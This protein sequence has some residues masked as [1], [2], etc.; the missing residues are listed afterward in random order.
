MLAVI[1]RFILMPDVR[2]T[3]IFPQTPV[4]FVSGDKAGMHYINTRAV[5]ALYQDIILKTTQATSRLVTELMKHFRGLL[6]ATVMKTIDL[7]SRDA[8]FLAVLTEKGEALRARYEQQ[9]RE[10]KQY[11]TADGQVDYP[12]PLPPSSGI[13]TLEQFFKIMAN[14]GRISS[15]FTRS[16]FDAVELFRLG[17]SGFSLYSN[18]NSAQTDGSPFTFWLSGNPKMGDSPGSLHIKQAY[19]SEN[20]F[21]KHIEKAKKSDPISPAFNYNAHAICFFSLSGNLLVIPRNPFVSIYSFSR[22]AHDE[23]ISDFW[24]LVYQ[25]FEKT[26]KALP[27]NLG[28]HSGSHYAQTVPHLHARIAKVR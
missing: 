3:D 25:T 6:K 4:L 28:F 10:T 14:N 1:Q 22:H 16:I 9:E 12:L 27:Y 5:S 11:T 2:S 15:D 26:D 13:T 23:E 17:E 18:K 19:S 8:D 7:F 21:K 20:E 24:K